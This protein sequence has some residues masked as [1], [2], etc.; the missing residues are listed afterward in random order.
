MYIPTAKYSWAKAVVD[1][2]LTDR[3]RR[4]S[5][6]ALTTVA[7]ILQS[8]VAATPGHIGTSYL[9]HTYQCIHDGMDADA[10]GTRAAY[11]SPVSMTAKSWSELEW[12]QQS[13]GPDVFHQ[14]QV[15]DYSM[16]GIMVGDGSGTGAGGSL[17]FHHHQPNLSLG[18]KT[19]MGTWISSRAQ[20]QSSNWREL[21]TLV[22]FF[23]QELA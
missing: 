1:Y 7:G 12:W 14:E 23:H 10:I 13:L 11:Y 15:V 19:W 2:I 4:Y 18:T 20:S 5:R 8:I 17:S 16:M 21:Q 3:T 22:E 9:I 6:L